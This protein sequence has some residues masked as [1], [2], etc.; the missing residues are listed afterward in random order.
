MLTG[1]GRLLAEDAVPED[2][3]GQISLRAAFLSKFG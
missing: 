1:Y 3:L 2:L